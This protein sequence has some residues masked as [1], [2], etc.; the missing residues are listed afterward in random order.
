LADIYIDILPPFRSL[1]PNIQ[2]LLGDETGSYA[3][4]LVMPLVVAMDKP[5]GL[6][7]KGF[8]HNCNL[9]RFTRKLAGEVP[10]EDR[11]RVWSETRHSIRQFHHLCKAHLNAEDGDE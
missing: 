3:Y 6:S 2:K 10:E 4:E 11:K 1:P 5:K 8:E 9:R 7:R